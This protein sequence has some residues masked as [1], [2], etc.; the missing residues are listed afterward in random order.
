MPYSTPAVFKYHGHFDPTCMYRLRREHNITHCLSCGAVT[1]MARNSNKTPL[2][3]AAA[4][5][6][7]APISLVKSN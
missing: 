7:V 2:M 1:T 6:M 5:N 4:I 3:V